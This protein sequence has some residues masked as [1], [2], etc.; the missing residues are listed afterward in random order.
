MW[1]IMIIFLCILG[2]LINIGLICVFNEI[3]VYFIMRR[4]KKNKKNA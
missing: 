3:I 2:A 1:I 4:D